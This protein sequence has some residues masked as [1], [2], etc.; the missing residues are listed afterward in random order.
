M[1]LRW[2]WKEFT[3]HHEPQEIEYYLLLEKTREISHSKLLP[4]TFTC[5]GKCHTLE[6]EV[7]ARVGGAAAEC[8]VFGKVAWFVPGQTAVMASAM[9]E[10]W[11][12]GSRTRG[13]ALT[14]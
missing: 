3:R 11:A 4:K 6:C 12:T 9:N 13:R 5:K 1:S 2:A 7:D 10:K 8:F 14:K